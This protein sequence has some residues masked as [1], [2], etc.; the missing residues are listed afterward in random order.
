MS[1][2]QNLPRPNHLPSS[3]AAITA[4]T[5]GCPGSC[6]SAEIAISCSG[7]SCFATHRAIYHHTSVANN[8]KGA[9]RGGE[10]KP[11]FQN[12]KG[13]T[14]F[15]RDGNKLA[16]HGKYS[17]RIIATCTQR[18]GAK[19]NTIQF[20]PRCGE[21]IHSRCRA[22]HG[23]IAEHG[24]P[25]GASVYAPSTV[26]DAPPTGEEDRRSKYG[27]VIDRRTTLQNTGIAEYTSFHLVNME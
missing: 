15:S 10:S 16:A 25:R 26:Y 17:G 4:T 21:N 27:S 6:N 20:S 5:F 14:K 22:F 24:H 11:G 13:L 12:R 18:H 19:E 2:L 23:A 7:F 1:H 3:N 8:N 9:R